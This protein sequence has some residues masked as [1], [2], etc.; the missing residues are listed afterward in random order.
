MPKRLKKGQIAVTTDDKNV[1]WKSRDHETLKLLESFKGQVPE[2]KMKTALSKLGTP[3]PFDFS[4]AEKVYEKVGIIAG[5]V[6]KYVDSIVGDFSINT[7]NPNADELLD[8]FVE[9]TDFGTVIREWIREALVKGNGFI[10][11]DKKENKIRVINANNMFVKRDKHGKILM[12]HQIVGDQ[13]NITNVNNAIPFEVDEIAHLPINKIANAAYGL[14]IVWPNERTI[15]NLILGDQNKHKL[16]DRKAGAPYHVKVGQPGEAVDPAGLQAFKASL[17]FMNTRTE[18]VT[19]GNVDINAINVGDLG[20]GLSDT[21]E[22]DI[23]MLSAGMEIPEVLFGRGSIPEGLAKVQL[24]AWQRKI[25]S[26][27]EEVETIIEDKILKPFLLSNGFQVDVEFVWNLPGEE[28]INRRIATLTSLMQTT[29][30]ASEVMRA[31]IEVE[32]AKILGFKDADKLLKKPRDVAKEEKEREKERNNEP[33]VDPEREEEEEEIPQPEVPGAKPNAN[34]KAILFEKVSSGEMSVKE[35]VNL[36]EFQDFT[37]LDYVART[38]KILAKEK[39]KSLRAVTKEDEEKGLLSKEQIEK[40]R[41]VLKDGFK[42]NLTIQEIRERIVADVGLK[43]R[44]KEQEG[45][46][47]LDEISSRA[48][49]IARTETVRLANEALLN[50]YD[51]VGVTEYRFLAAL[52][53]RTCPICENLNG[54]V[55][56]IKEASPGVNAPP[57][58]VNCRC[59]TVAVVE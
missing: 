18:W 50:L 23:L 35:F 41:I 58:H 46:D 52:S 25:R 53:D 30:G 28:E 59:A 31:L 48:D 13:G 44:V 39:F 29:V 4:A 1:Y 22:D 40:L 9:N 21:M 12:Y 10:E 34:S 20:K 57:I 17:Q 47:E 11:I 37:Y 38:L 14:G 3:H 49:A 32:L 5:A 15:E 16:V 43:K 19:D 2:G 45:L 54:Q 36:Q 6:N 56:E 55:F 33:V 7:E 8:N 26:I 27:Q 42:D 51:E 24:E